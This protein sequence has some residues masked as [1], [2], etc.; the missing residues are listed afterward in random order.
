MKKS[1]IEFG[2]LIRTKREMQELT[3][4][5]LLK[6]VNNQNYTFS[7]KSVISKWENGKSCPSPGT[8]TTLE[9]ILQIP[10]GV[11][12]HLAGYPNQSGDN[13]L[14][15][16]TLS[17]E[18]LRSKRLEQH[19]DHLSEIADS[20]VSNG[21]NS[22]INLPPEQHKSNFEYIGSE[23]QYLTRNNLT[24]KLN[25]NIKK[26]DAKYGTQ[27]I[28]T[29]WSHINNE[30]PNMMT[31]YP[32]VIEENPYEF[33]SKLWVFSK[34]KYFDGKCLVCKSLR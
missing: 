2:N 25:E 31:N 11:L 13:E 22:I 20:L 28:L 1:L 9:E 4:T 24:V 32:K 30:F 15:D 33:I 17:K 5:K 34:R 8:I 10:K 18:S 21:L 26:T 29:L 12:L 23:G 14:G 27:D 6:L 7:S 19:F 3:Q 16:V